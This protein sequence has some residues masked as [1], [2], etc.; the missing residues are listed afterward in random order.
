M[1]RPGDWE[2]LYER[3]DPDVL[4]WT[5]QELDPDL[6]SAIERLALK[7]R[8]LDLGTGPGTQA[9]ALARRGFQVVAT[10]LSANA[11]AKARERA[12]RE[13][14]TV[15]FRQ[16]DILESWLDGGF[17]A[18][19]DRGCFHVLPP[20]ARPRYVE[21]VHR[22][23]EPAGYFFLK[24]FSVLQDGDEGPHRFTRSEIGSLFEPR[25]EVIAIADTIYQGTLQEH[26]KALFCVLRQR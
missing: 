16:D 18:I 4:P 26:P 5:W 25:F 7:G 12:L 2:R 22:L 24:C 1:R 13:G 6:G 11:V 15:D 3:E 17:A 19:S 14:V 23:L 20:E 10:D 21:T 8:F 9:I